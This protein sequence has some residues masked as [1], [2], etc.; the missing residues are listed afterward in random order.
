MAGE[1]VDRTW[2]IAFLLDQVA[3]ELDLARAV[4]AGPGRS[5]CF[6]RIA[7]YCAI[8]DRLDQGRAMVVRGQ[9]LQLQLAPLDRGRW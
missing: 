6:H 1:P 5:R 9:A 4:T 2:L 7:A 8:L 3:G